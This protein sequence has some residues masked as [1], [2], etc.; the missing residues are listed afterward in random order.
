MI[1]LNWKELFGLAQGGFFVKWAPSGIIEH[2]GIAKDGKAILTRKLTGHLAVIQKGQASFWI[3]TI[4]TERHTISLAE[5]EQSRIA[6]Y[7]KWR[8]TKE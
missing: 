5:I 8:A 1:K 7:K 4:Y 2:L 3:D 6:A